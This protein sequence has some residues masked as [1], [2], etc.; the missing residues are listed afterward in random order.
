VGVVVEEDALPMLWQALSNIRLHKTH[1]RPRASVF[2]D[3]MA[4]L[5]R[6]CFGCST[7][8]EKLVRLYIREDAK[9][10]NVGIRE[11]PDFGP[12]ENTFT[13]CANQIDPVPTNGPR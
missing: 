7:R 4:L 2:L 11:W 1:H 6:A 13:L 9:I 8:E 5:R 12:L 3:I 10:R